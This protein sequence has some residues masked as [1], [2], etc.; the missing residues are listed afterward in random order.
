MKAGLFALF[1]TFGSLLSGVAIAA[2]AS[3]VAPTDATTKPTA[4]LRVG[5]SAVD[6]TPPV[7]M[8]FQVPQ[9]PPF[10]VVPARGTHDPL[11]AKCVAFEVDGVRA[12]IVSCDLTSIP[13]H[14]IAEARQVIAKTCSTPPENVMITATHTHTGPNIRP[15]NFKSA[16]PE[17]MKIATAYLERLPQLMAQSVHDAEAKLTD[18]KPQAAIG[19]VEGLA[20]NRRYLMQDGTVIG[21]VGKAG[22]QEFAQIVRPAGP[23]DTSLPLVY[24]ESADG[25]PLASMVNFSMHLDTTS[26]FEYSSDYAYELAKVLADVK[27]P[28]MLTHFTIGAAGNINHHYLMRP[29]G[30]RRVKSFGE[31]ARIGATLAAEVLR[32]Y[33]HMKPVAAGPLK[34]SHEVLTLKVLDAKAKDLARLFNNAD[35]FNDGELDVTRVDGVYTF[36]AEVLVVTLGNEIAFVGMPGEIFCE[37]GLTVKNLSPYRYTFINELANGHIG[38]VPDRKALQEGSYGAAP[39]STRCAPGDG[40]ALV[41]SAVRQLLAHR[42]IKA[43]P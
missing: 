39:G 20:F 30:P 14:F 21:S 42:E 40:E 17:Q 43:T 34:V 3:D 32:S 2:P 8:P 27:G 19:N 10:P 28:E 37:L 9:R 38:Y 15:R 24:F 6:I 26:G 16:N 11:H 13:V 5:T 23:T 12:A 31:A 22:P 35:T 7:G 36:H 18:A 25:K 29:E 1:L 41:D 33:E 4:A